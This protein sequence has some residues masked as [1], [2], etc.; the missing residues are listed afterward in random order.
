MKGSG[1]AF[2]PQPSEQ[3]EEYAS[4]CGMVIGRSAAMQQVANMVRQVALYPDTTVLLQGESGTG[5]DVVAR[6][7]HQLSSRAAY[8]FVDI[9]CAAIPETLL[10][11]E[12][13]GVEAGAFTDAKARRDG[14]VLRADGGTLFLDEI[15]SMPLVLQA[16]LLRFLETRSFRRVG[17]TREMHVDLRVISATNVDLQSAVA[18]RAFRDDLFYRLKVITISLPALRERPEDIAPLVEHFLRLHSLEGEPPLRIS[19]EAMDL[20]TRYHWPGNVRELRS[21]IQRGQILC[22]ENLI[23]PEHLPEGLCR[24]SMDSS[25]RLEELRAQLHLPPGGIDLPSFLGSIEHVF[26]QEALE[27][28]HGNQVQAAALL[29]ISRDQLRYRLAR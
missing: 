28:C 4:L 2:C 9:N 14:Y 23:L 13:F 21:V 10:E 1:T 15:G 18:H 8:Q 29:H 17:S 16:K 3:A 7:I 5:K 20:L 19:L 26:I 11:T 24:A 22:D 25:Q 12:L 27:R 6:A